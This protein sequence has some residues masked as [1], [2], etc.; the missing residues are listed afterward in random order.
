MI[1]D[2][3]NMINKY[4]FFCQEDDLSKDYKNP[5][6]KGFD[7]KFKEDV[8]N[9]DSVVIDSASGLMWQQSGSLEVMKFEDA[10][11]WSGG[12]YFAGFDD[13]RLPTLEEAMSLMEREK[14][15][16]G[17]YIDPVFD[18]KQG[19]IWTSDIV[20]VE[21]YYGWVVS[22]DSGDC[23]NGHFRHFEYVRAVRS[24]QTSQ[25]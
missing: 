25:E 19:W 23:Q 24:G 4:D 16:D 22:F 17:L 18:K 5:D 14:N 13:W 3:R 6:G 8:I 10:K 2:V 21:S 15:N 12:I 20:K 1:S 7:K 11:I 9:G